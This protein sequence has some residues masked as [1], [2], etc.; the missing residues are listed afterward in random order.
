MS[1]H[2]QENGRQLIVRLFTS[3]VCAITFPISTNMILFC[4]EV[5]R[6]KMETTLIYFREG[7]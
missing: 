3:Y 6:E 4:F 5:K 2:V 7:K 1:M